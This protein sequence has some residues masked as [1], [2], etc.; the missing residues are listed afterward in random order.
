MTVAELINGLQS[1]L[2]KEG[3]GNFKSYVECD[4]DCTIDSVYYRC[5]EVILQSNETD[6]GNWSLIAPYIL[7]C[8]KFFK[9]DLTVCV[10]VSDE[11]LDWQYYD[12]LGGCADDS[13]KFTLYCTERD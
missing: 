4:I 6:N 2:S 10:Q 9:K 1:Y 3:A 5:G 7:H 8:L 12:V 13:E 11:D